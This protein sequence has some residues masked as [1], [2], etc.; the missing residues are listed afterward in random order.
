MR[1]SSGETARDKAV[2]RGHAAVLDVLQAGSL[3]QPKAQGRAQL[4]S[5]SS[6]KPRDLARILD[7][8]NAEMSRVSAALPL[9]EQAKFGRV[10]ELIMDARDECARRAAQGLK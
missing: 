10:F 2:E 7:D 5:S 6:S 8:L 1:D 3:G 4:A 9:E